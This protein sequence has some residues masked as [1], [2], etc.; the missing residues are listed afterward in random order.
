MTLDLNSFICKRPFFAKNRLSF[1]NLLRTHGCLP[2]G[3]GCSLFCCWEVLT[4]HLNGN[5][6]NCRQPRVRARPCYDNSTRPQSFIASRLPW[7][8]GAVWAM[9][10][11]GH[12]L[13]RHCF[14]RIF[15]DTFAKNPLRINHNAL[16]MLACAAPLDYKIALEITWV[17]SIFILRLDSEGSHFTHMW[18]TAA[19]K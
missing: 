14:G 18:S 17:Y 5:I 11:H 13:F 10:F 4:L 3:C 6:G 19:C 12:P 1:E 9:G 7:H 15:C 8:K 2:R 16:N